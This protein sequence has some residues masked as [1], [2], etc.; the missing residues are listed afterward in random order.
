M[1][2]GR[3]ATAI[4]KHRSTVSTAIHNQS[5]FPQVRKEIVRYLSE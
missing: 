5:R 2:V 4:G 1:S 3:L